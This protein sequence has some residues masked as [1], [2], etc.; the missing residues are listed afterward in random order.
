MKMQSAP[1]LGLAAAA[2]LLV[3]ALQPARAE[4]DWQP[5]KDRDP[6]VSRRATPPRPTDDRPPL[7]AMNGTLDGIL[8]GPD[9]RG[10]DDRGPDGPR[11][12]Q[13][14]PR[15]E[16][17]PAFGSAYPGSPQPYAQPPPG[18]GPIAATAG[19]IERFEPEP[20]LAADGS[21]LPQDAWRGMDIKAVEEA[22]AG[23]AL[24]PKSPALASLWLRLMTAAIDPPQ[25]GRTPAHFDAIRLEALYRAGRLTEMG[26][27]LEGASES[28]PIFQ[29]F[30]IRHALAVGNQATACA[31]SRALMARRAELPLTLVS[32]L[33]LL[34]GYCAAAEGNA[35][36]AG[37]A[38]DLAREAQVDAPVALA[39]LDALAGNGRAGLAVPKLVRVLD[40]R[41]LE[42]LGPIDPGQ[43]LDKAE[44]ALVAALAL[45]EKAE[46]ATR[47][48]A[49]EAAVR[50][51]ALSSVELTSAYQGA[52]ADPS[53]P[54]LRRAE[55]VRQIAAEGSAPRKLQLARAALDDA[56]KASAA[57]AMAQVLAPLMAGVEPVP[58]LEPYAET[59][60]EIFLAV[61]DTPK[62]RAFA[63]APQARHWLAL[64]DIA[65]R[66]PSEGQREANLIALDDMV[67]RNRFAAPL[68]HRLATV[69][70]AT[71]VNVPIPL[72]EAASR[73]PQPATGYLAETGVLPQLQEAA[74]K[75]D[76]ARTILLSLR[77][78]GPAE[79][80]GLHI[81]ALGDTIRA[82]R[83]AGLDGD[84]RRFGVEAL[85]ADWPR[86]TPQ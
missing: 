78:A 36:G 41:L 46:P 83:R 7:P 64:V 50:L 49:A 60:T 34:A 25:G 26:K 45:D 44:P 14:S 42:L 55:L 15:D 62:A 27:R 81:I 32:E 84:A 72:W 69:L 1:V 76:M 10:S 16:P 57:H 80:Q 71:D 9:D 20:T 35:A 38:A 6:I 2:V 77:A 67:R 79:A 51:G 65:D 53:V 31:A 75:K 74:K 43:I 22:L 40:Y 30:R 18:T 8:H 73:T 4:S 5:F 19:R 33:H 52:A 47:V 24:P 37:L 58:G 61:G 86:G 63:A 70:D 82:L 85:I 23:L 12:P 29:A 54:A 39:A 21:G 59:A 66:G 13:P 3:T 17:P 48:A 68:L 11:T 28:D 56:R